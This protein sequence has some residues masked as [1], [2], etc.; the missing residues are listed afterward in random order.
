MD[1]NI[2]NR[3]LARETFVKPASIGMSFYHQMVL[4]HHHFVLNKFKARKLDISL[5]PRDFSSLG[6]I[7]ATFNSS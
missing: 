6:L 4:I 1:M 2:Q 3:S 7:S 5:S